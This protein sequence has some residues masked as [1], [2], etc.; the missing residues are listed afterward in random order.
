MQTTY[1]QNTK[2][3]GV[4]S[5]HW[6]CYHHTH[7]PFWTWYGARKVMDQSTGKSVLLS[8]VSMYVYEVGFVLTFNYFSYGLVHDFS[9]IRTAPYQVQN[10]WCVVDLM[11]ISTSNSFTM[12]NVWSV[13]I[14]LV[15]FCTQCCI[16]LF[17]VFMS[18][19]HWS[20][21]YI[22][23]AHTK[24]EE[25]TEVIRTHVEWRDN[26]RMIIVWQGTGQT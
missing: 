10:G 13:I 3:N 5:I 23:W 6:S 19:W 26:L 16:T 17:I 18:S 2:A 24:E 8:H 1:A 12:I 11:K 14:Q 25:W 15:G 20:W 9:C 7:Q 21:Q 4:S 22:A